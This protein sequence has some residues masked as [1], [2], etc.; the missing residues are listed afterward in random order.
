MADVYLT[1]QEGAHHHTYEA[2]PGLVHLDFGGEKS[3]HTNGYELLGVEILGV[4]GIQIDGHDLSFVL[5]K[6]KLAAR[7]HALGADQGWFPVV[8]ADGKDYCPDA[9]MLA[10]RLLGEW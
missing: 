9:Y 5:D 4:Q 10:E 8:V 2:R 1:L 6:E 3:L 7:L